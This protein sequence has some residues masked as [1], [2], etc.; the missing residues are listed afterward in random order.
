MLHRE[1]WPAATSSQ[2][3]SDLKRRFE[4]GVLNPEMSQLRLHAHE[5]DFATTVLKAR[6]FVDASELIK[7]KKSVRII[8][9]SPSHDAQVHCTQDQGTDQNLVNAVTATMTN[10]CLAMSLEL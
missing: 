3:D 1:A 10:L 9:P 2:R 6:Q 7:P 4:D 8:S 5:D